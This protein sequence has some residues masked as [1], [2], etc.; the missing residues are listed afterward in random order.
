MK[1]KLLT[2]NGSLN[3]HIQ[4]YSKQIDMENQN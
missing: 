2:K 3:N 1:K 4:I